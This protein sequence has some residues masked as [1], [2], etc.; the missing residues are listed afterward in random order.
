MGSSIFKPTAT[1]TNL[2]TADAGKNPTISIAD[3][4]TASTAS[5]EDSTSSTPP[6]IPPVTT[7]N[8]LP[9][10]ETIGRQITPTTATKPT[11][12]E[13]LLLLRSFNFNPDQWDNFIAHVKM[14]PK[15]E[16]FFHIAN[17]LVECGVCGVPPKDGNGWSQ[18]KNILENNTN[19][20]GYQVPNFDQ[21]ALDDPRQSA[22][23]QIHHA[24]SN[25]MPEH[26]PLNNAQARQHYKTIRDK[27]VLGALAKTNVPKDWEDRRE[28][29]FV[30][31]GTEHE[32]VLDVE[33]MKLGRE[34]TAHLMEYRDEYRLRRFH[35]A[36][37]WRVYWR[38]HTPS[39]V[40]AGTGVGDQLE[41]SFEHAKDKATQMLEALQPAVAAAMQH[42]RSQDS[43]DSL[44]YSSDIA[45][46]DLT[47]HESKDEAV[48][49]HAQHVPIC[50]RDRGFQDGTAVKFQDMGPEVK[51]TLETF[52]AQYDSNPASLNE[53][54][55]DQRF[56]SIQ[57]SL[58]DLETA[59]LGYA[60]Y[61][62]AKCGVIAS[63]FL[64][65][66]ETCFQT[67]P[68]EFCPSPNK[69]WQRA[70]TKSCDDYMD[71]A[72]H[73]PPMHQ[74]LKD[75]NRC[76]QLLLHIGEINVAM[77]ALSRHPE[78]VVTQVK[79]RLREATHDVLVNVVFQAVICEVQLH[80]HT[81]LELKKITHR[82]YNI[83]RLG[84]QPIDV[85]EKNNGDDHLI[86]EKI[87][88]TKLGMLFDEAAYMPELMN[89]PKRWKEDG[90]G[91]E[92][93]QSPGVWVLLAEDDPRSRR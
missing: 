7:E 77:D 76:T 3:P 16:G 10:I 23:V 25:F 13:V 40:G 48:A 82:P 52:L 78:L 4:P 73:P 17:K 86:P 91:Y 42:I 27:F 39:A 35:Q 81:I 63:G 8:A 70:W 6:I 80:F 60:Y 56:S 1:T 46:G 58:R 47:R 45:L 69:G 92:I 75:M 84:N 89:P 32:N 79:N 11:E 34:M 62:Y 22:F 85:L 55:N 93:E 33:L 88:F 68:G 72:T 12:E 71:E 53:S 9:V 83:V 15:H 61:L 51:Q 14:S 18:D 90:G 50:F 24:L 5:K 19:Q 31:E 74:Y 65:T 2:E 38:N 28:L 43:V 59:E 67:L 21:L 87:K 49:I 29:L 36:R 20:D 54:H 44:D 37:W 26:M 57:W 64:T 66:I 30:G 41:V